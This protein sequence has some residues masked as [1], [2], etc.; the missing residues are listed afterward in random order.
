M[1]E[2][3]KESASFPC[4]ACRRSILK[5]ARKCTHCGSYQNWRQILDVS[6]VTIALLITLITLIAS[7]APRLY[8]WLYAHSDLRPELRQVYQQYFEL[9][10][11]N[12]GNRTGRL[13]DVK[14]IVETSSGPKHELLLQVYGNASILPQQDGLVSAFVPVEDLSR[15]VAWPH[16]EITKCTLQVRIVNH[17]KPPELIPVDCSDSY[18]MFCK[19][20][21]AAAI[22]WQK[23]RAET[24]SNGQSTSRCGSE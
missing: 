6:Q 20:S 21:E 12:P 18:R 14:L 2:Q 3:S 17:E 9:F 5:G 22:Q 24:D 11:S 10:A 7:T 15:F 13:A 4:K 16:N 8:D 19:A 1:S 23:V